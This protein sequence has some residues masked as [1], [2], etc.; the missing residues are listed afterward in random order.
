MRTVFAVVALLLLAATGARAEEVTL[1]GAEIKS[2]L[3]DG[4]LYGQ[5]PSGKVFLVMYGADGSLRG[6]VKRGEDTGKWW[7]EG[8]TLC[9]NWTAWAG[10]KPEEC[11]TVK[12]NGIEIIWYRADGSHYRTWRTQ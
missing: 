6:I 2:L 1:S 5:T 8:D 9:R 10:D 11:F 12:K 3:S 4:R 7:V